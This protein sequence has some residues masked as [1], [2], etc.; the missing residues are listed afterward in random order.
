MS[1]PYNQYNQHNQQ[2]QQYPSQYGSPAPG[3][4]GYG[5]PQQ[6]YDQYNQ[7]NQYPHQ[8]GYGQGYDQ[9]QQQHHHQQY[10]GYGPPAQGGFQHGQSP[11]PY[12]QH[13]Q[14]R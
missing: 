10:P 6:G 2:Y 3:G 4:Q 9:Q 1:D 5:A 7:Q 11:A 12:D 13:N 14:S 8:Q